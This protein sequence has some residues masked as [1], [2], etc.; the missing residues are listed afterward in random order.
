MS[1]QPLLVPHDPRWAGMAA[2]EAARIRSVTALAVEHI[3]STS[4]PGIIAKPVLDL[5]GIGASITAIEATREALEGLGY[6]WRG[7]YGIPGRRYC[8]RTG[9]LR[10]H[11]HCFA[12]GDP[13]IRR[14]LA[15]RDHLR[16]QPELA[17]DYARVK[18]DCAAASSDMGDYCDCK[19][20]WIKRVEAETLAALPA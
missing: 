16:A 15:F 2:G 18:L 14:H 8:V 13:A 11:L 6:E 9:E 7:E 17:A 4:I 10:V 1:K 20:A 5:L 19:D 12:A 3:G